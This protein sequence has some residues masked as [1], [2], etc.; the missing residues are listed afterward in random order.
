MADQL[1]NSPR[2]EA[3]LERGHPAEIRATAAPGPEEVGVLG[4]AR[5]DEPPVSRD[6]VG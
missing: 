5:N 6:D 1:R 3:I 2:K 4:G